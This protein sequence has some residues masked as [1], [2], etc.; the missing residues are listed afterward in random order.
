[1]ADFSVVKARYVGVIKKLLPRGWAWRSAPG[2][3]MDK[4]LSTFA[5]EAARIEGRAFDFLSEMNPNNAF[6]ML[7]NWERLLALPDECSPEEELTL[8]KRRLRVLQ[9][10]TTGGGQSKAFY[11][12]IAQQLGY[13][14][15]V[16]DVENYSAFRV[17]ISRVGDP[18]TNTEEWAFAFQIKAPASSVRRFRVG[19]SVVGERLVLAENTTLECVIRR[20]APAHTVPVFSYT[21]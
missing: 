5:A 16:F 8:A 11:I 14:I 6:E 1:M 20:F 19:Q 12:R 17:G 2:S 13:D 10:L 15:G 4:L 9:K 7:D 3:V 18:L 21:E